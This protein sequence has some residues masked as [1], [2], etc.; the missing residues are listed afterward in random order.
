MSFIMKRIL[1]IILPALCISSCITRNEDG[2]YHELNFNDFP[3]EEQNIWVYDI[4]RGNESY[5]DS[6]VVIERKYYQSDDF[7]GQ[8]LYAFKDAALTQDLLNDDTLRVKLIR[9]DGMKL[10]QYGR[11][12]RDRFQPFFNYGQTILF[13]NPV[14][15]LDLFDY[16][17]NTLYSS[18][19]EIIESVSAGI[20]E[21]NGLRIMTGYQERILADTLISFIKIR[22]FQIQ[23]HP[24]NTIPEFEIFLYYTD[25][26]ILKIQGI[27]G[28]LE[29]SA[30]AKRITINQ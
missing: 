23:T 20:M 13:D 26:G 8:Y 14:T 27:V 11:E 5:T 7:G 30:D 29:Y 21:V 16:N 15:L 10:K 6:A 2:I 12:K 24:L 18:G 3:L 25:F 19:H 1:F 4:V 28:G 17:M 9:N 22:H